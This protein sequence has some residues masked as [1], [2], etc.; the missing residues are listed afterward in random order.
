MLSTPAKRKRYKLS[1][2][3]MSYTFH[4]ADNVNGSM[5]TNHVGCG[6]SIPTSALSRFWVERIDRSE[7]KSLCLRHPHAPTLPSASGYC[8]RLT[9]GDNFAGLAVWGKG[10]C[11]KGTEKRLLSLDAQMDQYLELN[12]FFVVDG[13]P[14]N[15]ASKFLSVTHR[16][17]RKTQPN[18]SYLFTYAA[19]FQGLVGTIYQASG[20]IY[21]G[22]KKT[23]A[24]LYVPGWGLIH[25]IS[26]WRAYGIGCSHAK[27]WQTIYPGS[28]QWNGHNFEYLYDLRSTG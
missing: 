8:Y 14:P 12:R 5:P 26:L 20:Y 18:V 28:K 21:L 27:W 11:P 16:L 13:S 15:T 25:R 2:F 24:F 19:G 10:V 4:C 17:L 3:S 9:I 6:G 1:W 7:A 22:H 23:D